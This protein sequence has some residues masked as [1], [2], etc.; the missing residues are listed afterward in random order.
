M[1]SYIVNIPGS[2]SLPQIN[3][4]IRA[5]EAG[6]AKF[7]SS[8]IGSYNNKITNLVTF[9]EQDDVPAKPTLVRQGTSGPTGNTLEWAGVMII[10]GTTTSVQL[11]R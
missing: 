4:M 8:Q 5:E 2:S 10:S 11:Y 7:L 9:T 6:A 1:S 3:S